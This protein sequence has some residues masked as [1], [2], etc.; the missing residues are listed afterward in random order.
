MINE[1]QVRKDIE[2]TLSRIDADLTRVYSMLPLRIVGEPQV[3]EP[4]YRDVIE[5]C[6]FRSFQVLRGEAEN[7]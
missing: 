7:A 2:D 3:A 5:L 4:P 6:E 1:D